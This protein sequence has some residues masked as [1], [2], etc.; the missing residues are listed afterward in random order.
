MHA[1]RTDPPATELAKGPAKSCD[2]EEVRRD[3]ARAERAAAHTLHDAAERH[4]RDAERV[5]R[6]PANPPSATRPA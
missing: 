1:Y 2:I 6:V 5:E 4:E 3:L